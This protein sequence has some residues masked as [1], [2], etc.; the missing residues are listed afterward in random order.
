[1]RVLEGFTD[2]REP[3]KLFARAQVAY[4]LAATAT[5][6]ATEA[7]SLSPESEVSSG[8]WN[9]HTK[10]VCQT[11]RCIQQ[12]IKLLNLRILIATLLICL[13]SPSDC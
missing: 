9:L 5:L 13:A 12:S 3:L 4:L 1:M 11:R 8:F 6:L 10:K 2:K 7:A